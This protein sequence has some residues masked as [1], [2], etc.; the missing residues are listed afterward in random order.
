MCVQNSKI[1]VLG[2]GIWEKRIEGVERGNL[3]RMICRQ[4]A[5]STLLRTAEVRGS[6]EVF[7][8]L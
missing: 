6:S 2:L 7:E 3:K 8:V 1:A 5:G 4:D